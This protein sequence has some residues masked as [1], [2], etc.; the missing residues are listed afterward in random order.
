[1]DIGLYF[2]DLVNNI[3]PAVAVLL[4]GYGRQGVYLVGS[5]GA[6]GYVVLVVERVDHEYIDACRHA[7]E[8][9]P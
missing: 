2:V 7:E 5:F 6:L 1:M 9:C 8:V 3:R 4:G